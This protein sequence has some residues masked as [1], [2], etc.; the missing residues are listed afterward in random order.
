MTRKHAML[1]ASGAH[2]WL[3]CPPSA[4]LEETFPEET[5]PYAEEGTFA[6][7]YAELLLRSRIDAKRAKPAEIKRIEQNPLWNLSMRD[8]ITEYVAQIMERVTEHSQKCPDTVV[9]LEQ[10]LDFSR[11]V[12]GGF[13]TGDVVIISDN[14][15]EVID[16]KYG[17]G[18][19]VSAEDNPQLRLYGLG[20]VEA[21]GFLY[22]CENVTMTI[23]Q[24]RLDSVSSEIMSA[25]EL[26]KWAEETVKPVAALADAGEGEFQAGDH[27][28]FCRARHTCRARA[29]ESLDAARK[30][31]AAPSLLD[32]EEIARVLDKAEKLIS[33]ANDVQAY[34][35]DQALNHGKKWDGWKLVEGRS[36]RKYTDED[37]IAEELKKRGIDEAVLYERRFLSLTKLEE[38]V[39]NKLVAELPEGLII[40]PPGKPTLVP[41][42][43]KR[44]ELNTLEA[45]QAAF[46]ED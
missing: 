35:F 16:L 42:S 25:E 13:G 34:A 8:Y 38:A 28:K 37:A 40:K 32:D 27:C 6:H 2:R 46:K 15:V 5:S 10:R 3:Q 14:T 44:P 22:G 36:N 31:F 7:K 19:P 18:V 21:Y 1:S 39:G 29:E 9:F 11:W 4:A 45:A 24:P 30:A 43:D 23:I 17:A 26:L 20:A 33:W 41:I 12:P